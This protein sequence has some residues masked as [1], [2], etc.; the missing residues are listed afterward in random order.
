MKKTNL[1]AGTAAF[2]ALAFSSCSNDL[3]VDNP[4]VSENDEIRYLRISIAN[5]PSTRAEGDSEEDPEE[6]G[7]TDASKFETGTDAENMVKDIYFIFYDNDGN[8]VGK[9]SILEM[10]NDPFEDALGPSVG[11]IA[12]TIVQLQIPK[13]SKRPSYVMAFLN[14]VK[15]SEVSNKENIDE[16]RNS[17]RTAYLCDHGCF[18]MNNSAY[19]GNN[20][21]TGASNVKMVGAPVLDGRLHNTYEDADKSDA[22]TIDIYVE[23]YAAKVNFKLNENIKIDDQNIGTDA[24]KY[25]L[26]YVPEFWTVNADA[27]E[28]YASKRFENSESKKD[29]TPTYAQ[30]QA[31][32]GSWTKWNDPDNYRSYWACSPGYYATEFPTVSDDIIDNA[33]EGTG[34]GEIVGDYKLKYYSY[35]QISKVKG[36]VEDKDFNL[37]QIGRK[38]TKKGNYKYVLENTMGKGAFETANPKAAAPSVVIVGH[39]NLKKGSTPISYDKGFCL[40][41][42][43]LYYIDGIPNKDKDP[44]AQTIK[45]AMM[46]RNGIIAVDNEGTLLT[47]NN[48]VTVEAE[49]VAADQQGL[50]KCF[51]VVHPSATVRGD[52]KLPHRYVTLQLDPDA[53]LTENVLYYKNT[54]T[55]VWTQ[56][57]KDDV[58]EINKLLWAQLG[59]ARIYTQN[60]GY[61]SIPIRHLRFTEDYNASLLNKD[62]SINW[63]NARIGDFGLVRNHV[64]SL[65]V[66]AIEGLASGIDNPDNPLVPAMEEDDYWVKYKINI[67][68]W[69]VVPV[70]GGIVLK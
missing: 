27:A 5:P 17:T 34:A 41:T 61:F 56:I 60:K 23:R 10:E 33:T 70:Q 45:T 57:T 65:E 30:V 38:V 55:N 59:N 44:D 24:N 63:N 28:M 26:T 6:S 3:N 52:Q 46:N 67:L 51:K 31:T 13:G 35:N 19:Y 16:L 68:N 48:A 36:D 11:K 14:P 15:Y 49:N 69:R 39:Y 1:L 2:M 29:V 42:D 37:N 50:R 32:L 9:N 22:L 47:Y 8:V 58:T 40:Y 21:I 43:G 20:P 66:S 64:Y 54:N 62:G 12:T 53:D 7:S 25:V 4:Q 18:A